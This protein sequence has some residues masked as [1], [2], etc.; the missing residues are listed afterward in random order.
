[1]KRLFLFFVLT[2]F[3][4]GLF[5]QDTITKVNGDDI[6]AKVIEVGTG[7]V[8][9]KRYDNLDGPTFVLD[10]SEILM[11]RFENGTKEIF[12]VNQK[13]NYN[14]NNYGY[15]PSRSNNQIYEKK[16]LRV[17]YRQYSK[18][19]NASD[20]IS[21]PGDMYNPAV[22][23][24]CSFFIPGLGQMICGE[25][26]RGFGYLLGYLG[27]SA[28]TSVWLT[29]ARGEE[30]VMA[31]AICGPI[32]IFSI[33]IASIVDAVVVAK[34]KNMYYQDMRNMSSLNLGLSPYF[35]L[36]NNIFGSKKVDPVLGMSIK[37]T[38]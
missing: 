19:Y 33:N 8:K 16:D 1:M 11:I 15:Y 13:E 26:G 17:R 22:S 20:Y 9:Y 30:A 23:G 2:T 7:E 14:K 37:L 24:I 35:S 12:T 10:K 29:M 25:V 4:F 27:A 36:N 3:V 21:Q 18:L 31:G 32:T 5:A 28:L 6:Y 38:F 34:K